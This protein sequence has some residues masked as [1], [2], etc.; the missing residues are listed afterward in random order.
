MP[1]ANPKPLRGPTTLSNLMG[2]DETRVLLVLRAFQSSANDDLLRLDEAVRQGGGELVRRIAHRLA[3]ACY[4][5][6]EGAAGSQLDAV[7][8]TGNSGTVDPV[9]TQLVARARLA[10]IEAIARISLRIDAANGSDAAGT[11]GGSARA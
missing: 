1:T 5:V 11:P 4:L 10:L 9:L 2:G 3:M 7:A 8:R 6:D